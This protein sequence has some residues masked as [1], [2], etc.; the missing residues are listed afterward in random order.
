MTVLPQ[1]VAQEELIEQLLD[2][3]LFR[4]LADFILLETSPG[5]FALTEKGSLVRSIDCRLKA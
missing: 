2:Q 1:G 4:Q 3:G 5:F